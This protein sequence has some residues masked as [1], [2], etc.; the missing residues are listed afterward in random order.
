M[1]SWFLR[2]SSIPEL[3]YFS[4]LYWHWVLSVWSISETGDARLHLI[5]VNGRFMKVEI[6]GNT[7]ETW[8][9]LDWL[10][11]EFSNLE[12]NGILQTV[13]SIIKS[14]VRSWSRHTDL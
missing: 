2:K 11:M 5:S 12:S 9:A 13:G 7:S 6:W 10:S 8:G 3:Y 4:P 1:E 14:L